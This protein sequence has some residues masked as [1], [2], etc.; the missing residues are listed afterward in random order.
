MDQKAQ[1]VDSN[2]DEN[3]K[4]SEVENDVPKVNLVN[5]SV[6]SSI[7]KHQLILKLKSINPSMTLIVRPKL[8]STK[9]PSWVWDYFGH[10]INSE[11]NQQLDDNIYCYVC[12]LIK[13]ENQ[14]TISID[15]LN[16]IKCFNSI[17]KLGNHSNHLCNEH[18]FLR[19]NGKHNDQLIKQVNNSSSSGKPK[20]SLTFN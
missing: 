13:S 11:T 17:T 15:D 5:K 9:S 20:C 2:V 3:N 6:R 7:A 16:E 12:F 18:L 14:S 8:T 4:V 10:L 1:D 19:E